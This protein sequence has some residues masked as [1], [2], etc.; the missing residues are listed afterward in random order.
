MNCKEKQVYKN[1]THIKYKLS[2]CELILYPQDTIAHALYICRNVCELLFQIYLF[3]SIYL[4]FFPPLREPLRQTS[5]FHNRPWRTTVVKCCRANLTSQMLRRRR[6]HLKHTRAAV[7]CTPGGG[8]E[9]NQA[10]PSLLTRAGI[11][12]GRVRSGRP[13]A[14]CGPWDQCGGRVTPWLGHCSGPLPRPC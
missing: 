7:Q 4:T 6:C 12:A 2:S 5:Y 10:L 14:R 8:R 3:I 1:K 9:G 11:S 13:G